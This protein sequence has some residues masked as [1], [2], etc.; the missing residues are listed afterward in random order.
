MSGSCSQRYQINSITFRDTKPAKVVLRE[1]DVQFFPINDRS[2][3]VIARDPENALSGIMTQKKLF[4]ANEPL[5]LERIDYSILACTARVN[6]MVKQDYF[7]PFKGQE[8]YLE[9]MVIRSARGVLFIPY[10]L[11]ELLDVPALKSFVGVQF[12]D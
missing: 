11:G 3:Q 5:E 12:T 7:H 8:V 2:A 6:H 1:W 9:N 10:K 4:G